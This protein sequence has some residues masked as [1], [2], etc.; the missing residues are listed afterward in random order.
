M[1]HFACYSKLHHTIASHH[2]IDIAL[3]YYS[4]ARKCVP[5]GGLFFSKPAVSFGRPT[6]LIVLTL[7]VG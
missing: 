4:F 3:D 2:D 7:C 1:Y 6:L 5:T